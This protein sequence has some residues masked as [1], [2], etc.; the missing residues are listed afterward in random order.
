MLVLKIYFVSLDF[1]TLHD[2]ISVL[3][4]LL[5]NSLKNCSNVYAIYMMVKIL[6]SAWAASISK[7]L[8][9]VTRKLLSKIFSGLSS[10]LDTKT[11]KKLNVRVF[12]HAKININFVDLI[13]QCFWQV[14]CNLRYYR[15][16]KSRPLKKLMVIN[17]GGCGRNSPG[18]GDVQFV[19][20][21]LT[22]TIVTTNFRCSKFGVAHNARAQFGWVC[23][24]FISY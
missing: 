6:S 22:D 16:R 7:C 4:P 18:I 5:Q 9:K 2:R 23:N 21:V 1:R 20:D 24:L 14:L 8:A 10:V 15:L 13:C 12:T 19:K 11:N 17:K 3:Y